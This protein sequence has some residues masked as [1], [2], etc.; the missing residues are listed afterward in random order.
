M[1]PTECSR[2][3]ADALAVHADNPRAEAELE[4]VVALIEAYE[5]KR[6]PRRTV[7]GGKGLCR[8]LIPES[9]F[10]RRI[11]RLISSA[12]WSIIAMSVAV[13]AMLAQ[14]LRIGPIRLRYAW[15]GFPRRSASRMWT[16]L[17][18]LNARGF[19]ASPSSP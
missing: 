19:T 10:V 12:M 15:S 1:S 3:R 4:R 16:I 13:M 7:A 6:W 17:Q 11:D 18:T 2:Q 9:M 14:D 5:A 8:I